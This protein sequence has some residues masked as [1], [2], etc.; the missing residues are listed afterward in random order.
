M[1]RTAMNFGILT[2]IFDVRGA[3][4][5]LNPAIWCNESYKMKIYTKVRV[6]EGR[7]T[8]FYIVGMFN[9][10]ILELPSC[11]REGV[12][13]CNENFGEVYARISNELYISW[14]NGFGAIQTAK[15]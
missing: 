6:G 9:D 14:A 4:L 3:Y 8:D 11:P 7:E 2:S 5:L 1:Y 15:K 10:Y 12:R 13:I